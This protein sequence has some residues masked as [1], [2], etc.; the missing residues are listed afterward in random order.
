MEQSEQLAA[1]CKKIGIGAIERHGRAATHGVSKPRW[2][3]RL[4]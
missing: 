1:V 4:K 3:D 2:L